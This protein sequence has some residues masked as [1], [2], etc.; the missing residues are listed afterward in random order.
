MNGDVNGSNYK[1]MKFKKGKADRK[2]GK[3]EGKVREEKKGRR[4]E[5]KK[6]FKWLVDR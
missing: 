6:T 5:K 4:K 1:T 3:G 2:E